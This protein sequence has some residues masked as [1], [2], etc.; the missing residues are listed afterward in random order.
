MDHKIKMAVV[1]ALSVAAI[2]GA[3]AAQTT[4]N[5]ALGINSAKTTLT[6]AIA[7]AEQRVGGKA[8]RAEFEHEKGKA[9]FEVEVVKGQSVVDVTVD[10]ATGKVIAA[11]DDK[12]DHNGDREKHERDDD[13]DGEH[14]KGMKDHDGDHRKTQ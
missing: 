6:Q 13:G 12:S 4:A 10:P 7:A 2:G 9:M 3:Y 14:G 8:S 1:A 11:V 5:D